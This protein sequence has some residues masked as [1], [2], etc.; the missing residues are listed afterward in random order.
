MVD[1]RTLKNIQAAEEAS[2]ASP[3]LLVPGGWRIEGLPG[4]I[5]EAGPA[6]AQRLVEFFTAEI[7]NPNTRQA[8]AFA[9]AR[10]FEWCEHRN[11]ALTGIT[12]FAVAAYIEELRDGYAPPTVKQHLAAIRTMF[13]Y[14]VVG[15]VLPV[16][17]AA[18]V[19]GSETRCQERQDTRADGKRSSRPARLHR[20][21]HVLRRAGPRPAWNHGV[22]LRARR[23]G[24]G[25]EC[26]GLLPAGQALVAAAA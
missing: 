23:R 18:S 11:L 17:P 20:H 10:F 14:L 1:P 8:Y 7:R 5:R 22:F 16:N 19:R 25:H 6:A 9:T 4:L 15:Q 3:A 24:R 13:D 2:P 12:P 26:R 21:R